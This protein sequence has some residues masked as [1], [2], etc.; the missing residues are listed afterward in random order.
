MF[1]IIHRNG[2]VVKDGEGLGTLITSMMSGGCE[3]DVGGR[4][5]HLNK[6]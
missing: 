1:H 4:G 6:T 5:P 2:E 3:V